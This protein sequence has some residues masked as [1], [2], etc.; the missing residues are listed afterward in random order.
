M[1]P[2]TPDLTK[3][4]DDELHTKRAELQN[5]L[6]FA[7][8]MGYSDMVHQLNLLIQDYAM[9]VEIRNKKMLEDAQR[10]GRLG[11][12]SDAKDITR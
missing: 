11:G 12:D 9:E 5:R 3:L 10:S 7:Y 2:L 4:T 6:T 1:H 8:R